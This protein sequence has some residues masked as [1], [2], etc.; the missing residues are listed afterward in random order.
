MSRGLVPNRV[1]EQGGR[2]DLGQALGEVE[3]G[4]RGQPP[5]VRLR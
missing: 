4:D 1:G 2:G 3:A 5:R